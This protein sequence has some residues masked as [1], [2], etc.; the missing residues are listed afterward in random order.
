M[1]N[2]RIRNICIIVLCVILFI[3]MVICVN[4]IMNKNKIGFFSYKFYIMS[5]DSLESNIKTGDLV[6]AKDI[7]VEDFKENDDVIYARKDNLIVKK[8]IRVDKNGSEVNLI[9]PNDKEILDEKIENTHIEGKVVHV[10]RG[11][12][13]VALFIQSPMG[14]LNILII[15]VCLFIIVKKIGKEVK[16]KSEDA[17]IDENKN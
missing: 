11:L 14:T 2:K 6:I 5:S 15:A 13:N 1:R 8:V 4:S 16:E 17:E 12:G 10:I 7:K 9:I 3:Y